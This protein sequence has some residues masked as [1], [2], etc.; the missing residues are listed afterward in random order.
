MSLSGD[1]A[2]EANGSVELRQTTLYNDTAIIRPAT[3]WAEGVNRTI[4]VSANDEALN[5][6]QA[7]I[8]YFRVRDLNLELT[9]AAGQAD[10]LR[11]SIGW[12][13]ADAAIQ[14]TG[15]N[16][17]SFVQ[18]HAGYTSAIYVVPSVGAVAVYGDIYIHYAGLGAHNGSL[19][20]PIS[21]EYDCGLFLRCSE[22]AHGQIM[23]QSITRAI[24]VTYR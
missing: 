14:R 17:E 6:V 8:S 23:W 12:P 2:A 13:G 9:R 11:Q 22:F 24:N 16:A 4:T 19:G 1:L 15:A 20:L 3:R 18:Y 5:S 10:A 21:S 7:T